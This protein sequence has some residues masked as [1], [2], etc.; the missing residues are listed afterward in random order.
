MRN[1]R[2]FLILF[3]SL[4]AIV[5]AVRMASGQRDLESVMR[6]HNLQSGIIAY[7]R[8]G[9]APHIRAVGADA[10]KV[11]RYWSLSKPITAAAVMAGVDQGLISLDETFEGATVAD[12]LRHAGGWDREEA[13]DPVHS[14]KS[15]ARCIDMAAPPKQFTPGAR[16][17]Y[18][19]LGYCL[20]GRLI[21]ERFGKPYHEVVNE[22]FPETQAMEYDEWL[23]PAGGWSGTAEQYFAFASR[24]VD[25]RALERPPY[26][27]K[28]A[29]YAM[30]WREMG[31]G[32]LSHYGVVTGTGTDDY[33]VV[34]KRDDW[35]AVGLFSGM[36][37]DWEG[38][39]EDLL[40]ALWQLSH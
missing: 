4:F 12:L 28:G 9:E 34:Y 29:Y 33:T 26:A 23:G 14:R 11:Y 38:A 30:G 15:P 2:A 17:A 8:A 22:L 31:N 10:G 39:R 40:P 7:G 24:P 6:H 32:T 5:F 37:A 16:A 27:R 3:A 35:V 25:K 1:L 36:P 13:G 19:N 18:S 20:L 21:E